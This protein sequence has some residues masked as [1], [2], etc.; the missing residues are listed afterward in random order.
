MPR[1]PPRGPRGPRSPVSSVLSRHCDFLPAVPPHFVSFVGRYRGCIPHFAL[2]PPGC[3]G[4]EPGVVHPVSPPGIGHGDDRISQVP[5][6]P[7]WSVCPCSSTPAGRSA[8]DP[9][10]KTVRMAPA[11]A[12]T[13]A[14]TINFSRLNSKAF[15]L[16]VYVSRDGYPPNRA[17]LASR[18]WVGSPGRAFHPQGSCERFP[19][20]PHVRCPPLPSFLA[21]CNAFSVFRFVYGDAPRRKSPFRNRLRPS[22]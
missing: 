11:V 17:R 21:Q 20:S 15:G 2:G 12:R 19:N 4:A 16:A 7:R 14:P 8:P 18:C 5:G 1:F 22:A 10:Y 13:K 3:G 6:E 9:C